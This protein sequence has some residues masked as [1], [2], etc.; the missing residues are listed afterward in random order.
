[1]NRFIV[2]LQTYLATLDIHADRRDLGAG[3]AE[4]ALLVALIAIVAGVGILA[5]GNALS[6]FFSGLFDLLPLGGG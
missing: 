2:F 1:M 3:I 4:Y 6:A 5:F